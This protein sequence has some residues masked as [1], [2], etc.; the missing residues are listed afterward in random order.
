MIS[1][2]SQNHKQEEG[3]LSILLRNQLIWLYTVFKN[4]YGTV[5]ETLVLV[6]Y[7]QKLPFKA[8]AGI[9]CRAGGQNFDLSLN[10]YPFFL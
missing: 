4:L 9:S 10:L 7:K 6:A 8:H 2:H 3:K 1:S 5:Q